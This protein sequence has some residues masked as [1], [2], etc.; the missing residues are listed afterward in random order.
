[1]QRGYLAATTR[2]AKRQGAKPVYKLR[3]KPIV[4]DEEPH[5]EW[6]IERIEKEV[7]IGIFWEFAAGDGTL[8]GEVGFAAPGPK[9]AFPEISE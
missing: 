8:Q 1:V 2:S 6:P 4:L 5:I 7:H 9:E 3:S